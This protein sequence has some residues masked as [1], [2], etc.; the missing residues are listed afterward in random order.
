MHIGI[1]AVWNRRP[2]S[3]LFAAALYQLWQGLVRNEALFIRYLG[4]RP[5]Y[6]RQDS[7]RI[8]APVGPS[9][10]ETGRIPQ[11]ILAYIQDVPPALSIVLQTACLKTLVDPPYTEREA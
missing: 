8:R 5:W 6:S 9:A 4:T 3:T 1:V 10:V 2:H 7:H 11:G